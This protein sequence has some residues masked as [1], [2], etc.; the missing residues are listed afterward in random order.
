MSIISAG[1]S[2][3]EISR[4]AL[5]HNVKTFKKLINHQVIF[6]TCVKANAYGHGIV[7]TSKILE[8]TCVDW[9]CVNSLEEARILR[10]TKIKKPVYIIGY[11]LKK[12]LDE[13]LKLNCRLV[14]YNKETV[15]ALAKAAKKLGVPAR[16][17]L[18]IETGNNRQGIQLNECL[19]FANF[20]RQFK[21]IIIEGISTHFANIEDISHDDMAKLHINSKTA[22]NIQLYPKFQLDNFKKTIAELAENNILIPIAHC[23]NSAATILFPQTHFNMIR[24]GIALYGLW[25]SPEVKIAAEK[26]KKQISLKPVLTWKTRIAQIKN[27]PTN[28]YI[29]Y[30]CTYKTRKTMRLAILPVGY[31][32]GYDRGLSNKS[33]VLVRGKK[34][35][36]RGRI[37]MN[38]TMVD[39]TNIP[40]AKIEDEVTLIGKDGREEITA[41]YLADLAGTINYEIASRINDKIPRIVC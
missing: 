6:S 40:E 1:L 11:V 34:A 38:I 4:K 15:V 28:S 24:P 37:C 10:K 39:I 8:K 23:A 19:D 7:E 36:V 17:H 35:P 25:P 12:N 29:G 20:C 27:I 30:G 18:K 32:D 9:F 3:I 26:L 41:E 5:V 33:R 16:I 31:Y 2:W 13:A 14:V 22:A 21:E